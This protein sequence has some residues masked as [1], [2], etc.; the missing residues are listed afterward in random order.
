MQI[1]DKLLE[2]R[3]NQGKTLRQ[4]EEETKI[5]KKYLAALEENAFNRIPGEVY[6]K[7]FIKGYAKQVGLDGNK[8]VKEYSNAK[9][10]KEKEKKEKERQRQKELEKK[11]KKIK[12]TVVSVVLLFLFILGL[13]LYNNF[14]RNTDI[15]SSDTGPENNYNS[16]TE[17]TVENSRDEEINNTSGAGNENTTDSE[18]VATNEQKNQENEEMNIQI[19]ATRKSWLQVVIDNEEVFSGF[20][21]REE[22][23][24]YSGKEKIRLKIGNGEAVQVKINGKVKGPWGKSGEVIKKEIKI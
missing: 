13:L 16:R 20:I 10:K 1:G 21:N 7:A 14:F 11:K 18:S 6:V 22:E 5:R 17:V 4:I 15:N 12:I 23:L 9:R 24:N 8:L 19:T 2:A 3:K